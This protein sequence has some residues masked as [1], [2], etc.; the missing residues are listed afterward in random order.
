MFGD[1]AITVFAAVF[2]MSIKAIGIAPGL[3]TLY[4]GIFAEQL[5]Y[6]WIG[7]H[8]SRRE[9]IAKW[10]DKVAAPFDRHLRSKTFRTLLFSKFIYGL[11]RAV[12][13]R[14]G[15]L[16]L[17]FKMFAKYTMYISFIWLAIIGG[18]GLIFDASYGAFKSYF[19]FA[20]AIP[21]LLVVAFFA[22]EWH[23]SKRLKKEL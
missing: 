5:F 14:S 6:Y 12:L 23:I 18:L 15:M 8:L 11:H 17:H 3:I 1:A 20:E 19:R 2:L 13:V 16:K 10:S 9:K 4:L 21:L 7:R 22:A